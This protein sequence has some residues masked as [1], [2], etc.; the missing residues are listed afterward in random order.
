L[1]TLHNNAT[2]SLRF[3][4]TYIGANDVKWILTQKS[5]NVD[6]PI[7][8]FRNGNVCIGTTAILPGLASEIASIDGTGKD[9]QRVRR[10][11]HRA[12]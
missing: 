7:F 8:N 11:S 4:Q 1:L 2:N 9:I 3:I 6:Y 5:N 12:D 10:P